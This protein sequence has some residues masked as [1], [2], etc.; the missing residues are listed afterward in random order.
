MEAKD[1]PFSQIIQG[2]KQFKIPVFQRDYSWTTTQC[3]QLWADINRNSQGYAERGHFI[4]AIVYMA[5]ADEIGAAFGR[6]LV[7]DGQQRLTSLTLLMV[8][9]RDHIREIDWVGGGEDSPTADRIDA[10]FLKNTQEDGDRNYK[11][12]LRRADDA[13][14]RSLIDNA[15][16]PDAFS[17]LIVEAYEHFRSLLQ[18]CDP[19][20]V[21]REVSRLM[22]V[23]VV[24]D[25]RHDDPQLVFESL[26]STGVDLGS[27]DLIRNYILM[28]LSE[29]Q[30]THLY[31]Q[32]WSSVEKSFQ[33][34]RGGLDSFLR[35]YTAI[36]IRATKQ[37]R[38]DRVYDTFKE[39]FRFSGSYDDIQT[40]IDELTRFAR[41]YSE[42]YV[43][44]MIDGKLPDALRHLR[45]LGEAPAMLV[46]C[47]YDRYDRDLLSEGD[48]LEAL[49]L[50]ESYLVRRAV[51]GLQTRNYWSVFAGIAGKITD[52]SP[53]QD[54]KVALRQRMDEYEFPSTAAFKR[55]LLED[56]LYT[57]RRICFYVLKRLENWGEKEPSP[58]D[59]Y[60]VEHIMPQT[61]SRAWKRMLGSQWQ[62][63]HENWLHRLGNLTLTAYNSRYSNRTFQEKKEME[64]GFDQSAVRL[65]GSVRK[66]N[67]W[68]KKHIMNRG[69]VL[70]E[71][72]IGIWRDVEVDA[73]LVEA[74]EVRELELA[75][76]ARG[77]A[78]LE[79]SED[80]RSLFRSLDKAIRDLAEVI[81]IIERR[82][83]CYYI[84]SNLVLE[85]LPQKWGMRVLLDVEVGDVD[86]PHS[87]AYNANDWRFIPNAAYSDWNVLV[88][89]WEDGQIEGAIA[90]IR[91]A[92]NLGGN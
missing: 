23:D 91:Q 48:F 56:D 77:P 53:L 78:D 67:V 18:D 58:V 79:M 75:A 24:L 63:I 43:R 37:I 70:T 32:Y 73:S 52:E 84:R 17:T 19:D 57:R 31:D 6:W 85:A 45:Q 21:Y 69:R 87:L 34:S 40:R 25:R 26:N 55:A 59:T 16:R 89:I 5:A 41:Y 76:A 80:A 71:R 90:I 50:I 22:V 15:R 13:T 42:F 65:N 47:L 68:N 12:L 61:L 86:D 46:M 28:R 66:K 49:S 54:L 11:L 1:R 7:V 38:N 29:P 4:G 51:C 20:Q 72:A 9:L 83:V 8:A 39:S 2:S 14:L 30:Q 35:D 74:T 82:S 36:E 3:S 33:G 64:G 88:D 81:V 92:F 27:S 44:P 62:N 60:T 10:C